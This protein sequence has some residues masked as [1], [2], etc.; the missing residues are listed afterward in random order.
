M[1]QT[2]FKL[3]TEEEQG[4]THA[5]THAIKEPKKKPTFVKEPQRNALAKSIFSISSG[6]NLSVHLIKLFEILTPTQKKQLVDYA[7]RDD[8]TA[9]C[10]IKEALIE[11]GIIQED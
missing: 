4:V 11:Q 8:R 10:V 9:S 2:K 1:A 6:A 7:D 3:H 5:H